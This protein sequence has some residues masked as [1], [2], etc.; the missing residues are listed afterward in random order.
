MIFLK[1]TTVRDAFL[2]TMLDN[3]PNSFARLFPKV[4]IYVIKHS[5]EIEE[6]LMTV[7][8][9]AIFSHRLTKVLRIIHDF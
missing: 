7:N 4:T 9:V 2:S 3:L 1:Y 6:T 5:L 8:P